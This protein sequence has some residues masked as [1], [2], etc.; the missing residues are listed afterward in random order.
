MGAPV[1]QQVGLFGY[2][3]SHSISPAFQQAA[4]DHCA[5]PACYQ[6][7]AVPPEQLPAEVER[8]RADDRLGANV[9]IPHKEAVAGLVDEVDEVARRLRA[10]N[11]IVKAGG[12]LIGRNTDEYGFMRS[13]RETGNLDPAG[14]NAALLGAGGAARAAAFGLAAAGAA[15]LTIAN[16]TP[17]R[18]EAL[19]AEAR[20]DG[21]EVVSAPAAAD[22]LAEVC[23]E[24]DLV[25]NATSVGMRHGPAEGESPLPDGAIR[26]GAV[27]FDM[28]YTPTE[29]PLLKQAAAAGARPVGGLPMLVFQG[30]ASFE[31]WTG[32]E[33]PVRVM[34]AAAE[35]AMAAQSA[36]ERAG[37]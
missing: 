7:W 33:A 15:R 30:A 23:G 5:I 35:A 27:V 4:L 13:L 20:R 11:T 22:A 14:K 8:L 18:A 21:C 36:A 3:L 1:T 32:V 19:A 25:V 12:R 31:M 16:R 29:T 28:V 37:T 17:E 6:R 9:T 10:V 24:A 26:Q 34:F 2:P